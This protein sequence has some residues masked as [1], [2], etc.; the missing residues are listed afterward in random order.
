MK[1]KSPYQAFMEKL[2]ALETKNLFKEPQEC[3]AE[4][5]LQS[6]FEQIINRTGDNLIIG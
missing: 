2:N 1:N 6:L 3:L 5:I 4:N